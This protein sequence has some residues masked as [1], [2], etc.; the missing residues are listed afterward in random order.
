MKSSMTI[1]RFLDTSRYMFVEPTNT[2]KTIEKKDDLTD[3]RTDTDQ[4]LY[5]GRFVP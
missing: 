4:E 5:R 1:F 2:S 3:G